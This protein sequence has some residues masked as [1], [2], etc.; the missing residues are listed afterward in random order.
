MKRVDVLAEV[1]VD[2]VDLDVRAILVGEHRREVD[3]TAFALAQRA[4]ADELSVVH[5]DGD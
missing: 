3:E 2:E 1:S 4:E 5:Q